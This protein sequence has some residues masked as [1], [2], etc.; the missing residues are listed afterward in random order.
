MGFNTLTFALAC[1]PL[2][3]CKAGP[4]TTVLAQDHFYSDFL[5]LHVSVETNNKA[6]MML[7]LSCTGKGASGNIACRLEDQPSCGKG[8]N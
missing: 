2:S 3:I 7:V 4:L 6:M 8:A 5:S 1:P